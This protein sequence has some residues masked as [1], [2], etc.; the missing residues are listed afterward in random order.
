MKFLIIV[1]ILITFVLCEDIFLRFIHVN[2]VYQLKSQLYSGGLPQIQTILKKYQN[3][4]YCITT[5]GGDMLPSLIGSV[6]LTGFQIIEFFNLLNITFATFGNHEFDLGSKLLLKVLKRSKFP[7][8]NSNVYYKNG[9]PFARNRYIIKEINGVKI[10]F[11]G[12]LTSSTFE[13]YHPSTKNLYTKDPIQVS[14]GIIEELE[15]Q[16]DLF[17]ALTHLEYE[18]DIKLAKNVPKI[19]LIL[20]SHDHFP[21]STIINNKLIIKSGS[22]FEHLSVIDVTIEKSDKIRKFFSW[23]FISTQRVKQDVGVLKEMNKLEEKMT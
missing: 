6:P 3:C 10:C 7:W 8:I 2:D 19:S 22:N 4:S 17:V 1:Q 5:F 21:L 23:K 16:V 18:I 15:D 20:G 9:K 11:F 14:K 12:L 13:F